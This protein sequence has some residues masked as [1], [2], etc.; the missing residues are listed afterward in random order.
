MILASNGSNI[1]KPGAISACFQVGQSFI[2]RWDTYV[3]YREEVS[4]SAKWLL[5]SKWNPNGKNTEGIWRLDAE[6]KKI[7]VQ[8][9]VNH[10]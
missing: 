4:E 6:T 9:K 1:V 7:V 8:F 5:Q 3:S 2:V 10:T